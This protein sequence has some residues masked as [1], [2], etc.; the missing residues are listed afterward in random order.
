MGAGRR[1]LSVHLRSHVVDSWAVVFV[2]GCLFLFV[3]VHFRSWACVS[4]GGREPSLVGGRLHPCTVGFVGGRSCSVW[5]CGWIL[6]AV[7]DVVVGGVVVTV[8]RGAS[9]SFVVE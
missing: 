2:R 1:C 8:R 4:V 3:L 7:R 6:V 9:L 5:W